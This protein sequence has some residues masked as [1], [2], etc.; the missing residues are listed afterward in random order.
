MFCVFL[1]EVCSKVGGQYIILFDS[2]VFVADFSSCTLYYDFIPIE[3]SRSQLEI[4]SLLINAKLNGDRLVRPEQICAAVNRDPTVNY[5]T[6]EADS[7]KSAR[8]AI[9]RLRISI[10]QNLPKN[11]Q[12]IKNR[13]EQGYRLAGSVCP[14]PRGK[15]SLD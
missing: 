2:F 8:S 9:S 13:R 7:A 6:C 10:C 3:L 5:Y 4:L 14:L 1:K 15:V 12:V 11:V